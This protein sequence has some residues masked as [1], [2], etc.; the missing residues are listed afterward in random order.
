MPTL[1]AATVNHN[2][3]LYAELMV[4]SLFATH[5]AMP[6]L[7]LTIFD[8]QSEDDA[9]ELRAFAARKGIPIVQTGFTTHTQNN[10]HGEILRSFVLNTPDCSHYLFLDTDVCF[11]EA[12]TIGMMLDALEHTPDAFGV[13]PRMSWEGIH[14]IPPEVR[15]QNPAIQDA[16]LHPCC[17]LIR[18][19]PLF[20]T[21]IQEVGLSATRYLWAEREEYL[22]TNELMT[23]VMHT[24]GLRHIIAPPLIVHFFAVSYPWHT[25]ETRAWQE[26]QRDQRLHA[27]R[28]MDTH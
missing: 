13:G 3:S 10:S 21:I 22:D 25:A 8:N 27:L 6:D 28:A 1:A 17:A 7:T 14:E 2:M 26:Q 15:A 23:R 4:R 18:N 16:R 5:P 9:T 24:H 12:D 19:T 20:R 11:I